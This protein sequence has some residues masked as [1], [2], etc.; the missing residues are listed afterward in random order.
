MVGQLRGRVVEAQDDPAGVEPLEDVVEIALAGR[1]QPGRLLRRSDRAL[2]GRVDAGGPQA[3]TAE[4]LLAASVPGLDRQHGAG[5]VPVPRGRA[6]GDER[7]RVDDV[8]VEEGQ[9]EAVVGVAYG[10]EGGVHQDA[11][12]V[13]TNVREAQAARREGRAEVVGGGDPGQGLDRP[14]RV[15]DENA[16][17]V[18]EL[19]ASQHVR[20]GR[21]RVL[22][23]ERR[24]RDHD[25]FR[26]PERFLAEAD[27]QL[28]GVAPGL[29]GSPPD[30]IADGRHR[31]LR[32]AR[33]HAGEHEAA[34]G[35]GDGFDLAAADRDQGLG[36]GLAGLGVDHTAPQRD[37]AVA[38]WAATGEQ[39]NTAR[40]RIDEASCSRPPL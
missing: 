14:Q 11:V 19:G 17:Q 4:E 8:T 36:H 39:T 28:R 22:R 23:L 3:G 35:V 20:G 24:R 16:G 15:V 12:H 30:P 34:A 27:L 32:L 38:S 10:V 25:V 6:A 9:G 26:A 18:L 7:Q 21:R 5:A 31:D 1:D 37:R 33:G 2:E 29:D 13:E 40:A